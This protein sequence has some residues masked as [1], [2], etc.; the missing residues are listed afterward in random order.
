[1][2]LTKKQNTG[3]GSLPEYGAIFM[4]NSVTKKECLRQKIFGLSS[5]KC[6]FVKHIKAGMILFLFEYESRELYGVFEACSDGAMNIV[7]DAFR[8]SGLHCPAQVWKTCMV[9]H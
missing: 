2:K 8:S 4:S 9:F 5:T 1:M 6:N 3:S 7:P